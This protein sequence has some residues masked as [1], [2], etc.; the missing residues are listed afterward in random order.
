MSELVRLAKEALRQQQGAAGT[1]NPKIVAGSHITW[2]RG[3]GSTQSG[4][5]I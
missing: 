4:M 2:T 3:D 1:P 5:S